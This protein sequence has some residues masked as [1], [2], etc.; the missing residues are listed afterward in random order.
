MSDTFDKFPDRVAPYITLG[1]LNQPVPV[2]RGPFRLVG[3]SEG[4]LDADLTFRWVPSTAVAFDGVYSRP[5][6]ALD[7]QPWF[8]EIDGELEGKTGRP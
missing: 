3:S 2:I 4:T 6:P 1:E 5:H 8:L 7:T